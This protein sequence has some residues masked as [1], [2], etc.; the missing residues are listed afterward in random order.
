MQGSRRNASLWIQFSGC[1]LGT[2]DAK[3]WSTVAFA[4]LGPKPPARWSEVKQLH[5]KNSAGCRASCGAMLCWSGLM[6][7]PQELF[8][9]KF[10]YWPRVWLLEILLLLVARQQTVL[11]RHIPNRKNRSSKLNSPDFDKRFRTSVPPPF[12]F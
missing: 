12:F 3:R 8:T 2:R 1:L 11:Q 6:T 5:R 4:G 9:E 10:R 7:G